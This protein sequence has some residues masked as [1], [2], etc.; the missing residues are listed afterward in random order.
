MSHFCVAKDITSNIEKVLQIAAEIERE[1]RTDTIDENT[2]LTLNNHRFAG[3][4]SKNSHY[5]CVLMK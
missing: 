1:I 5:V 3:N 2:T 4:I